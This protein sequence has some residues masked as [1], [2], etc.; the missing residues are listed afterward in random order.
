MRLVAMIPAA[1]LMVACAGP[2]VNV[3]RLSTQ[4][5]TPVPPEQVELFS[6]GLPQKAFSEIAVIEVDEGPGRQSSDEMLAAL[7][8]RAGALGAHAVIL[9]TSNRTYG[10]MPVGGMWMAIEGK[11][12]KG[13]AI[14]WSAR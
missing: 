13:T 2:T 9:S 4:P 14:R 11:H 6:M 10:A 3:A 8:Q 7:R 1:M 5:L 12:L